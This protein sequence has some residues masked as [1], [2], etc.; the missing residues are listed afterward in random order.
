MLDVKDCYSDE[1]RL[2]NLDMKSVTLSDLEDIC[3]NFKFV[4]HKTGIIHGFTTWFEVGFKNL[5]PDCDIDE[6]LLNTGPK[7]E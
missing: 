2:F 4:I 5:D 3:V 6:V 7:Y 1:Q